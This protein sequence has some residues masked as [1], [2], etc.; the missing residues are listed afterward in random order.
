MVQLTLDAIHTRKQNLSY[1]QMKRGVFFIIDGRLEQQL[2]AENRME[3]LDRGL[4]DEAYCEQ[5]LKEY[6][7]I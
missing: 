5:L 6:K 1:G 2:L 4:A 7:L 3:E